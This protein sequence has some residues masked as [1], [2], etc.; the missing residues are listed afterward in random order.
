M[1]ITG[2]PGFLASEFIV[3]SQEQLRDQRIHLLIQPHLKELA[4]KKRD[5]ILKTAP[6]L[7]LNFIEGDI[8]TSL[9]HLKSIGFKTIFHFAAVYDLGVK[10]DLGYRINV[11][12]TKNVLELAQALPELKRFIYIS[13]CYVSGK[14]KGAFKESDLEVNQS[15]NNYYEETKYLAEVEVKKAIQTGLPAIIYRPSIVV[16][17]SPTGATQKLDGPYFFLSWLIHQPKTAFVPAFGDL[18]QTTLNLVPCDYVVKALAQ[19]WFQDSLLG[20]TLHLSDPHALSVREVVQAFAHET[21][22]RVHFIQVPFGLVKGLLSSIKPLETLMG[23]PAPTLNYFRHP[24]HYDSSETQRLT[25]LTPPHFQDY[26]S[27]LVT[28]V[29]ANP[30]LRSKALF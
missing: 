24:T 25:G 21:G 11:L 14:H 26:V 2:F 9:L 23:I 8:T 19:T 22:H 3:S 10:R 12:G 16:G 6:H 7:M 17:S 5:E 4:Q 29:K 27:K 20:R 30:H 13:T 28:Y 1:L 15:F 18:D